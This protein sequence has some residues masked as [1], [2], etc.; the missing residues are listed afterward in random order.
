LHQ[1]IIVLKFKK[2]FKSYQKWSNFSHRP[3]T[4]S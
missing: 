2:T 3:V 1:V 4:A